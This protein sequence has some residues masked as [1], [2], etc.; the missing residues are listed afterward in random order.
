[1]GSVG[2]VNKRNV[3]GSNLREQMRQFQNAGMNKTSKQQNDKKDE[4]ILKPSI[5]KIRKKSNSNLVDAVNAG[6]PKF[7]KKKANARAASLAPSNKCAKCGNVIFGKKGIK[8][9]NGQMFHPNCFRCNDCNK[10]M[11]PNKWKKYT[12]HGSKNAVNLCNT[13]AQKRD[14]E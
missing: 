3:K 2:K 9:S 4:E 10:E 5:A 13:C 8:G 6:S 1:M 12:P 11:L 14:A 7:K